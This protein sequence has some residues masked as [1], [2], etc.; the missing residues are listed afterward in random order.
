MKHLL[1]FCKKYGKLYVIQLVFFNMNQ[2]KKDMILKIHSDH[3]L[4]CPII[5]SLQYISPK[6]SKTYSV[7]IEKSADQLYI[8]ITPLVK[9]VDDLNHWGNDLVKFYNNMPE[10]LKDEVKASLTNK[11]FFCVNR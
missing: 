2:V 10:D 3:P 9:V 11:D 4:T 6:G 7:E 1:F 5:N 8:D